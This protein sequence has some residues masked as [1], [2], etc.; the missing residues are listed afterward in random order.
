[1]SV[2]NGAQ[3]LNASISS[4]LNQTFTD[5]EFII[6]DDASQD[7]SFSIIKKF[8][9][10]D[11]RI[12]ILRNQHNLGL[13]RS[14][15]RGLKIAH[16][17]Y[18]ARQ[19]ADDLSI[20]KRLQIQHIYLKN[21]PEIFLIGSSAILINDQNKKIGHYLKRDDPQK[22]AQTLTHHNCILHP[23]IMFRNMQIYP[24]TYKIGGGMYREKFYYAQDYDFY[25]LLLT[26]K[27]KVSN[28]PQYLIKY[29]YYYRS[30]T[31]Q[32]LKTQKRFAQIAREFYNQRLKRGQD[33][34]NLFNPQDILEK[35]K[36]RTPLLSLQTRIALTRLF[37]R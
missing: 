24:P 34:Y 3:Y 19:D 20:S 6:I 8:S 13:T 10:K 31:F 1:M 29:R 37:K 35:T 18:I 26:A 30:L 27:K 2:F 23:S 14:L 25:L 12:K 16:G 22:T 15:N 9:C 21:H 32:N 17:K 28:L 4:I 5:F 36:N 11:P 7:K 33:E